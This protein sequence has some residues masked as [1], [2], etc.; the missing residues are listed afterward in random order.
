M[1]C[2]SKLD[3]YKYHIYVL[4]SA[5]LLIPHGVG[6]HQWTENRSAEAGNNIFD[7]FISHEVSVAK[8]IFISLE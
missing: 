4:L 6:L 8:N 3:I 7:L 5:I 2:P 1:Q